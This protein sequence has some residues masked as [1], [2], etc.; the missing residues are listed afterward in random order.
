[1][2][3]L[4][5]RWQLLHQ[6]HKIMVLYNLLK[7]LLG[8]LAVVVASEFVSKALMPSIPGS[9]SIYYCDAVSI[10]ILGSIAMRERC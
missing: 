7:A 10:F 6:D 4:I 8:F 1:M 5:Q 9:W 2:R 3:D